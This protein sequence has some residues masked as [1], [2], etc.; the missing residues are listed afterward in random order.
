[1]K[2]IKKR[3]GLAQFE[4]KHEESLHTSLIKKYA[5][6]VDATNIISLKMAIC[7]MPSRL[8]AEKIKIDCTR[9]NG[10]NLVRRI[11]RQFLAKNIFPKIKKLFAN[12]IDLL[13]FAR[14]YLAGW[15]AA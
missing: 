13:F 8:S 14:F 3:P 5:Y 1:M 7:S 2:I 6:W 9:K 4:I 11:L 10:N 12:K 15:L